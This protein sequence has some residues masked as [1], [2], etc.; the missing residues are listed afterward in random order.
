MFW[1]FSFAR[2]FEREIYN[3][4][5]YYP[6]ESPT[7]GGGNLTVRFLQEI[8][9]NSAYCKFDQITSIAKFSSKHSIVC[10]IPEHEQGN[11]TVK[12]SFDNTNW[13]DTYNLD[14][15]YFPL[16]SEIRN[17]NIAAAIIIIAIIVI[18]VITFLIFR[19]PMAKPDEEEP[20]LTSNNGITGK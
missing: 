16:P 6:Q 3:V 2:S 20:L 12:I 8:N 17:K 10:S 5:K 7:T 14:F 15:S 19:I 4:S 9:E 18:F 13:D 11:I 1:F